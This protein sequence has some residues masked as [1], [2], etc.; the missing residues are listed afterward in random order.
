MKITPE[1]KNQKPKRNGRFF[2]N[3][4]LCRFVFVFAFDV[5]MRVL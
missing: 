3:Q 2:E 1:K 5:N 4:T